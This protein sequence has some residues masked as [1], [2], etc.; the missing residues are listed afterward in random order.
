MGRNAIKH[1]KVVRAR[2]DICL[3]S[4]CSSGVVSRYWLEVTADTFSQ[5]VI[6][7][8]LIPTRPAD[9]SASSRLPDSGPD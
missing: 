8:R 6:R 1:A 5:R 3:M 7:Y 9:G 4:E 2:I